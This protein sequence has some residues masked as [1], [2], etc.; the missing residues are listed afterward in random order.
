MNQELNPDG[1][2]DIAAVL[3][4]SDDEQ[5]WFFLND[6]I[7]HENND[8]QLVFKPRAKLI[9][10][11]EIIDVIETTT[12]IADKLFFG[13]TSPEALESDGLTYMQ[14]YIPLLKHCFRP[15]LWRLYA[16]NTNEINAQYG[17]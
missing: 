2:S 16:L 9:K 11:G 3:D 10:T 8:V 13:D 12:F 7:P 5:L 1:L 6:S 17:V 14:P 15:Y 4:K